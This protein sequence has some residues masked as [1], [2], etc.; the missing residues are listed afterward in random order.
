MKN[1]NKP[2]ICY[3]CKHRG[4]LSGSAHS[5]CKHPEVA[6]ESSPL[7]NIMAIFASVGRVA[8]SMNPSLMSKL[9]IQVNEHGVRNGWCIW[10][11]NFDPI[12]LE[13]CD[14]YEKK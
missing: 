9:N 4:D 13:N 6:E 2:T 10:P 8:P 1:T 3:S 5:C 7:D 12:W 14:G 11:L